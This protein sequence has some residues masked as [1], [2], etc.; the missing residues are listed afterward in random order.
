MSTATTS[1][2]CQWL[3][4]DNGYVEWPREDG[5][6][7]HQLAG[8][9]EAFVRA[10][11]ERDYGNVGEYFRTLVREKTKQELDSD[12]RF[13]ESARTGLPGKPGARSFR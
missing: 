5:D 11:C 4:I 8:P 12:L 2:N 13:L 9:T 10:Q 3:T 7:A 6:L 1:T